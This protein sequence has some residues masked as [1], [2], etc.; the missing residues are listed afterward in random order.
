MCRVVPSFIKIQSP[1]IHLPTALMDP[2][3][4]A[5]DFSSPRL[6]FKRLAELAKQIPESVIALTNG[7]IELHGPAGRRLELRNLNHRS[8][9]AGRRLEW[10]LE[11]E[12]DFFKTF[13]AGGRMDTDSLMG[14]TTF[15]VTDFRA[16]GLQAFFSP[17]SDF[18]ILDTRMDLDVSL[19]LEG[20]DRATATIAA[21][22]P[23]LDFGRN[24]RQTHLSID[25]IDAR[26][27]LSEKR[28]AVSISELSARTPRAALELKLIVDE[29]AHPKIGID[30]NGRGDLTG[31]RDVAL[32]ML[33]EMPEARLVCDILHSGEVPQIQVN[34][35]G[36][37]WDELAKLNNLRIK[38]RL[39]NGRIYLPWIDL[40]LYKVSGDALISGGILE[41]HD[42]RANYKGTRG[43]NG[44]R[45]R[46][47][48]FRHSSG[49]PAAQRHPYG[50]FGEGEGRRT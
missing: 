42:L 41:G 9:H 46:S 8:Q 36:D 37:S 20:F 40:D 48:V 30:L 12:S 28:W 11:V 31:A 26:L 14:T 13:S 21:K 50:H 44:P 39:E 1:E 5:P 33:H 25:R 2:S 34:L 45:T 22:A 23:Q 43:E 16:Q 29:E 24:R 6:L 49:N 27:E 38:G 47:R 19:D 3:G 35:H 7:R 32:S 18:K 15:Q 17:D 10:S 4:S